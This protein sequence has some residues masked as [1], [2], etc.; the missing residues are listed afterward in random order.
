MRYAH[1]G[2]GKIISAYE[3]S[4]KMSMDMVMLQR[5]KKLSW[6]ALLACTAVQI[7]FVGIGWGAISLFAAPVV[8]E[9][10]ILRTQFMVVVSL[11]SG[12]SGVV[13]FFVF[14]P[15]T[16]K[17]GVKKFFLFSAAV[18]TIGWACMAMCHGVWLLWIGGF[19][20]GVGMGGINGTM[21][22][23]IVLQWF[24]KGQARYLSLACGTGA[25]FGIFGSL[26]FGKLI[27]SIGW[28]FPMWII[29]A[30]GVIACIVIAVFYKG[31]PQEN[32]L[33]PRFAGEESAEYEVSDEDGISPG[34]MWKTPQFYALGVAYI[35]F[36]AAVW[37]VYQNMVLVM[38]D[39]GYTEVLGVV[40]STAL[41]SQTCGFY[42]FAPI[43]DKF[44]S[45]WL[46]TI[47][48]LMLI[49]AI[50]ILNSSLPSF[51][52]CIVA[53]VLVGVASGC[54]QVPYGVSVREAFGSRKFNMK[55]GIIAGLIDAGASLGPV[56]V[57]STYDINGSYTIGLI[58]CLVFSVIAIILIF[59]GTK[60]VTKEK[61]YRDQIEAQATGQTE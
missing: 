34:M 16:Q 31:S 29:V 55:V 59:P 25:L 3:R 21:I 45:K 46:V 15:A 41:I 30:L 14:G 36:A 5:Q 20:A 12:I 26:A 9:L 2:F 6:G 10:G 48:E 53:A 38:G 7:A 54:V 61:Y 8:E 28:R 23:T 58:S 22:N 33:E 17:F 13:N 19:L 11:V 35:L 32:G 4:N 42:F 40:L 49:V 56:F 52:I 39:A 18:S 1:E 27:Y 47:S 57:S 60:R 50:L 43:A 44:G 24:A 51:A 37:S